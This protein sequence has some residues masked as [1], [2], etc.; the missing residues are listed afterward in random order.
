M[1]SVFG[2]VI[3]WLPGGSRG[4]MGSALVSLV[5]FVGALSGFVFPL[6]YKRYLGILAAS[7]KREGTSDR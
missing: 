3:G 1:P 5:A 4:A 2:A 7:G 6:L